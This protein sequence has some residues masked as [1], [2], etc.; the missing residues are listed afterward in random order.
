[1]QLASGIGSWPGVSAR[2]ATRAVADIVGAADQGL[3]YLPETPARGPGADLIGRTAG[4]LVEMPVDLQPSGWRLADAPGRDVRRARGFL[5]EDLDELAEAYD[6]WVGPLKIQVCGPWTLAASIALP[7]GERAVHDPGAARD[8]TASLAEGVRT[9]LADVARLV[10]GARPVVQVDEPALPAVLAG[11]LP[12]VSGFSRLRAVEAGIA[13]AGLT[14]VLAVVPDGIE[15]VVHCCASDVP[16]DLI[17]SAGAQAVA[18]DVSLLTPSGW[19]EIATSAEA[20]LRLWAG[21][22]PTDGGD[23][24]PDATLAPLVAAWDRLGLPD[25]HLA[26]TVLTPA[27]G[28]AGLDQPGAVRTQRAALAAADL[29]AER[30]A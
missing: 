18:V 3:P 20:G 21:V 14:E 10:P 16:I 11:T 19:D 6:G 29:L 27:C 9:H 8:L 1:M 7:R 30:L 5:R 28:L 22:V 4:L 23:V 25:D 12:T 15:T 2:E 17:R 26:S 13:Q 24:R